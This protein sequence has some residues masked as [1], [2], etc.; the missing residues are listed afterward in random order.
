MVRVTES[1]ENKLGICYSPKPSSWIVNA[2]RSVER[3]S[4][5]VN[6]KRRKRG[7]IIQKN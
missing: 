4:R 1:K 3:S 7:T 2:H 6:G 5:D